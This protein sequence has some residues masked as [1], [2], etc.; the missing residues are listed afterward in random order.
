MRSEF[1][2][3]PGADRRGPATGIVMY[4]DIWPRVR[5]GCRGGS[6]LATE[7]LRVFVAIAAEGSFS[8]AA[9]RLHHA[10][11]SISDK[12][13]RLERQLGAELFV[14]SNR[15]AD[16]TAAGRRLLPFAVRCLELC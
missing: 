15:G 9:T 5:R 13:A 16:L 4:L 14:R 8:R 11:P 12:I 1:L 3:I 6:L 10:Q 7:D 2:V